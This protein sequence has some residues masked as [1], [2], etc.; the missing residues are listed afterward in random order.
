LREHGSNIGTVA[1][2][3]ARD[4]YG[5]SYRRSGSRLTHAQARSR[6]EGTGTDPAFG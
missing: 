2:T 3:V 1:A 6:E 5:E 4:A